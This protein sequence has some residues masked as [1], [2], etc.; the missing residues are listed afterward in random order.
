MKIQD[1]LKYQPYLDYYHEYSKAK[2]AASG[3]KVDANANVDHKN[4]A[5]LANEIPKTDMIGINR[6]RMWQQL[7][8]MFGVEVADRYLQQLDEHRIYRHDESH[9]VGT[10]Y[11]VS[12]TMYPFL[13]NGLRDIG[14][15]SAAPKHLDSFCGSFINLV[16]AV[17][18]QFAGAVSTPE[19]L[20]YMDY[21][22][23]KDYGDDYYMRA[24]EV[25]DQSTRG[26]TIDQ[27]ITDK[28]AQVVYSINQP[29]AA[30]GNQA[31]FWNIAYFDR[32][33]FDGM[34]SD[35]VFPDGSSMNWPS[36]SWLQKR[37]MK[38]F[39]LER[40][41]VPHTFPVE[42]MNLLD[43]GKEFVDHEYADFTAE[44]L[45][46]G[47]S[48]FIYHSDSVDSLA[49]CCRLRNEMQDN[50][51]SYTLGAGGVS[52]GSKCVITI[53]VNRL[54]QDAHNSG[55][56]I[57]DAVRAQVDDVH[58]YL[59]AV[60]E[61]IKE[62]FENSMLPVYDA[63]FIKLEKQYLTVGINGFIEGAEFLSIQPNPFDTEY[64]HYCDQI[65]KPIYEANRAAKTEEVMMNAEFVPAENLGVKFAAW[66]KRD[67]YFVPR[68]CY[69]SYF[70]VVEDER[71]NVLD[72]L[73]LHGR[74]FTRFLDGGS[75]CHINLNEH[76][77]KEQYRFLMNNAIRTGCPYFT[78]NIP[79]T[80]CNDC[81]N[82]SKR[83]LEVCPKCGSANLDYLTRVIGYLKRVSAF[84]EARQQEES[85]RYY[86]GGAK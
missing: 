16:F 59:L 22:I 86:A 76:L 73:L 3:S 68:D 42:T 33:Y 77:S 85:R 45:A 37:F 46:E 36:V 41:I 64:E 69:N 31:V 27:M 38:W 44:M 66:D 53:N 12:M 49:S 11:C 20:A 2:N 19:F 58:K 79:N 8:K 78:F 14:G 47:H 13:F 40:L 39:N 6:L 81:G 74:K 67:G 24:G 4:I 9:L 1:L 75:A 18:A 34:F 51:F 84:S 57:S 80:V 30:R 54:V 35:F 25:V 43:D 83:R 28:F 17:A 71:C 32:P 15:T 61:I 26:R 82:I 55:V 21:F 50:T 70:Y 52:T 63:G 72:K 7:H 23:R 56:N 65:L 29:A 48:F 62:E 10:P 60:N 5:T